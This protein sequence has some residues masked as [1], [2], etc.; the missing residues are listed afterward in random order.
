[1]KEPYVA[2]LL[3]N[4]GVS[5]AF[6]GTDDTVCRNAA[7][8]LHAA[9]TAMISSFTKCNWMILGRSDSSSK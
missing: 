1:M 2:S 7:R 9:S 4:L 6:H 5:E 3:S 8:K